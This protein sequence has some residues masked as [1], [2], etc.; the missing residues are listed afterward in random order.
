MTRKYYFDPDTIR[1]LLNK[2][3]KEVFTF[4]MKN[5]DWE[6]ARDLADIFSDLVDQIEFNRN[7]D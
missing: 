5:C 3:P 2:T 4:C 7:E 1:V 6:D